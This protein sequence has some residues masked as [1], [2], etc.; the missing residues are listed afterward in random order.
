MSSLPL[1]LQ[2]C[3]D[4]AFGRQIKFG[5]SVICEAGFIYLLGEPSGKELEHFEERWNNRMFVC[6]SQA[7]ETAL[8]NAYPHMVLTKRYQ[9]R[10]DF[11]NINREKLARYK[12]KLPAGYRLAPFDEKAFELH[13][14]MHGT[15]YSSFKQFEAEGAGAVVWYGEEIVASASSFLTHNNAMELDVSTA[16][17]HRKKGL[18]VAC[19]AAMLL[20]C[21]QR[22]FEVHWDAQNNASYHLSQQLGYELEKTYNA[23]SFVPPETP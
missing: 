5:N 22:N 10:L 15:Q 13:P 20:N 6:L 11:C 3:L 19:C 14:F 23:Y 21:M 7:W 2:A 4:G 12:E 8:L 9:M 17:T 16:K 1:L 18:G